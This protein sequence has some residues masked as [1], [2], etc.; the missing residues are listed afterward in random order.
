MTAM[1]PNPACDQSRIHQTGSGGT[2]AGS[3]PTATTRQTGECQDCHA[4]YWRPNPETEW[5]PLD[6]YL[7][8]DDT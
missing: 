7:S 6:A 4:A 5:R 3:P 1:T 8:D 2:S